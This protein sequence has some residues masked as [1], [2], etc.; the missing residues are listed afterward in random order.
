MKLKIHTSNDA[1]ACAEALRHWLIKNLEQSGYLLPQ[2][3]EQSYYTRRREIA[4]K[5]REF[6]NELSQ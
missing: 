2:P 1:I 5:M 3:G 4:D 6:V